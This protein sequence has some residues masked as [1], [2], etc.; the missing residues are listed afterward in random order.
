MAIL[1]FNLSSTSRDPGW[2]P[3]AAASHDALWQNFATGFTYRPATGGATQDSRGNADTATAGTFNVF[4]S[5]AGSIDITG[6]RFQNGNTV[7]G[8]TASGG[9][10]ASLDWSA[11][12]TTATLSLDRA[13]NTIKNA[14]VFSFTGTALTLKNWVDVWVH[15]DNDFGQSI[16]VDGAKRGEVT[17][18]SGDDT[19]W[20]GVDSNGTGWTNHFKVATGDGNDTITIAA[21][22]ADYSVTSFNT[23]AYDGRWTTTDIDAGAGNDTV[24]GGAGADTIRLG[25]GDD[26]VTGAFGNDWIDG[27]PGWD[28]AIYV[29]LWVNYEIRETQQGWTV[30]DLRTDIAGN[31]GFDTLVGMEQIVFADR[32]IFLVAPNLAPE[33]IDDVI[34]FGAIGSEIMSV[35]GNDRDPDGDQLI[36]QL[37]DGPAFGTLTLSKDGSF[38]YTP[39][40]GFAGTDSFTYRA[41][42][43]QAWSNVA[44]VTIVVP[45]INAAPVAVNDS[46]TTDEGVVLVISGA[47]V[48]A[49]DSD[50][51]GDAL[52]ALLVAGPRNGTVTLSADGSFVYT[53]DAG[54]Y[55][56]D[57]FTYRAT[58]GEDQSATATVRIVVTP[59]NEAPVA[60]A[61]LYT[62]AED[63]VLSVQALAGVLAN[64]LDSDGDAL[65]AQLVSGPA[66][67]TLTL[68][69][70][71]AFTYVPHAEWNGTDS[72]TYRA[73]DGLAGSAPVTVTLV[74]G[75][76]NDTPEAVG[77]SFT[78]LE[79]GVL[80]VAGPGVLSN[81]SDIDGDALAAVL[82]RG[83][84]NGTL[85]L[86]ADGSF[87]YV[88][89]PD[90]FGND[91]FVYA[92][93][94]GALSSQATV[95]LRV[96]GT[97]DGVTAVGETFAAIENQT[98]TAQTNRSLLRNDSAPDGGLAVVA[99]TFQTEQGG[100][101]ELKANGTFVYRPAPHFSGNDQFTYTVRDADGDTATATV[102]FVVEDRPE[103]P[104]AVNLDGIA[105]GQGGYR[106]TGAV[107]DAAGTSLA[108]GRDINGDGVSDFAYG[109]PF[110]DPSGRSNAGSVTVVFGGGAGGFTII[111]AATNDNAGEAIAFLPD[112]NGDGLAEILVG[113]EGH[114][115]GGSS[116]GAAYVVWGKADGSTVDLAQVALGNGG[117]RITGA[118]ASDGAGLA[119]DHAGDVNG[120]GIADVIVGARL[121]DANG[122]NAG[123]AYVVFGKTD[124]AGVSLGA[125]GT[126]GF[127][128]RGA[129]AG[130][131]AGGAVSAAGDVN[132]DGY[133]DILVGA[134]FDDTGGTNNGAAFVVYG[135]PTMGT[136]ELGS[137]G[138]GGLRIIG[139][140]AADNAGW[141]VSAIGDLNGDGLADML[142]GAR[143]ADPD[144]SASG[145]AYVVYGRA[146]GGDIRLSDVAQGIGGFRIAGEGAGDWAGGFVSVAP[147]MNGDG[148]AELLIGA[149]GDDDGGSN[150]GAAYIVFG[151]AGGFNISLDSAAAALGGFKLFGEAAADAA[152]TAIAYAGDLNGDG[153]GDI[154]VGAPGVDIVSGTGAGGVY[155]IYGQQAWSAL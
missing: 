108:G 18:G 5:A 129:I 72:F 6:V 36:A 50:A 111:G 89:R 34:T 1:G 80:T 39:A 110:A 77:E 43:G 119:L 75:A 53:P 149:L 97:N 13:W 42:D 79:D 55:G 109:S 106:I 76:V 15:L 69:A 115:A 131:Q 86:N 51:D 92:A 16:T 26:T 71:G 25:Q 47:G 146:G 27:G 40:E 54:W 20:V 56:N 21:S 61:D 95:S 148:F 100:T 58:D 147:D 52:A 49:N 7:N 78:L 46:Y 107:G 126:A 102:V 150:A 94:D 8:N 67:G 11:D 59:V 121:S 81:D 120:D 87:T 141:S 85:T 24:T 116:A 90:F 83:P 130:D 45:E 153:L 136:V 104:Y 134:R 28:T 91:S 155:V 114:D 29:D 154:L 9:T 84:A 127:E 103:P 145:A 3:G 48:L 142:V 23:A 135:G 122:T 33:A 140:A 22:T 38:V 99:G 118:T 62:L 93:S 139:E 70:D 125:L 96:N 132:G 35:L 101:I 19:V 32:T 31:E 63:G 10:A 73:R 105:L 152:G 74:V 65:T 41:G 88:P 30:R 143:N 68:G 133:A 124:G 44:T 57:N 66:H 98:L 151:S 64:D 117:F 17:T 82:V 137:L 14:E 113:A 112:M 128:I 12:G 2:D 60:I 123:S 4:D 144:G 138:T 37:V